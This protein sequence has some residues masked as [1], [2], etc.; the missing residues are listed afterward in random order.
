[1]KILV[2][3]STGL[4][5]KA[6]VRS[7]VANKIEVRAMVHSPNR[8]DEMFGIGASEVCVGDVASH[9]DLIS[10][11]KDVDAV[12]YICPTAREDEAEIGRMAVSAAK[13]SGCS[14]TTITEIFVVLL[15]LQV[16]FSTGDL[17]HLQNF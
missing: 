16:P 10:V 15:S 12:Y 7:L 17:I 13:E 1:M 2:T 9:D 14:D 3:S 8:S 5:G 11:M 4:T 6:V